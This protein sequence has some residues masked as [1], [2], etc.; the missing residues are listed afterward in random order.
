MRKQLLGLA[1]I[2]LLLGVTSCTEE[3]VETVNDGKN[4]I[5]FKT[6]LGKQTMSR[7]TET[8]EL[9]L[10]SGGLNVYSYFPGETT[11]FQT[12]NLTYSGGWIADPADVNQPG[13]ALRYYSVHPNAAGTATNATTSSYA[14]EYTI[15]AAA[16]DQK[17][18]IAATNTTAASVV[19]LQY[20][21]ILSQVN[22]AVM[23]MENVKIKI[24]SITVNKI[25]DKS[26]YTF[27]T[28]WGTL[29]QNS[30]DPAYTYPLNATSLATLAN[31]TSTAREPLMDT[32]G[33]LMLMP[34]T[35]DAEADGTFS[36][37]FSLTT[38]SIV[39]FDAG[40]KII[41]E[42]PTSTNV[43]NLKLEVPGWGRSVDG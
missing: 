1:A 12:F 23:A 5:E 4:N 22:F 40:D 11:A 29:S 18:L 10:R 19:D 34:Q 35:F 38:T 30:G 27:G 33:A 14:F 20:Q 39:G 6:V 42:L 3:T 31:G 7:A 25:M 32:N 16:G 36:I 17:D 9:T 21:H 8:T 13:R 41:I 37:V 43:A 2:S 26:T 15:P 28:G 24:S